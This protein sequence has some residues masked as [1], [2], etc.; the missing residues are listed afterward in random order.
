MRLRSESLSQKIGALPE[1][2]SDL[3][4][5]LE[6]KKMRWVSKTVL[7]LLPT[8]SHPN[9]PSFLISFSKQK[10]I[11]ALSVWSLNFTL[12]I[13]TKNH[14]KSLALHYINE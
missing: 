6:K 2:K 1:F 13:V 12:E 8:N 5:I 9:L 3:S 14:E 7:D 10:N 4:S 11:L